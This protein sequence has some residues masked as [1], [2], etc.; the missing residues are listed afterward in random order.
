[1]NTKRLLVSGVAIFALACLS[2]WYFLYL[3]PGENLLPMPDSLISLNTER[4]AE[5]LKTSQYK[6]DYD[7]LSKHFVPQ[8]RMAFC[9]VATSSIV[10]NAL[11][12]FKSEQIN[13]D[14]LFDRLGGGNTKSKFAVTFS[15]M[16]LDELGSIL[17]SLG[18]DVSVYHAADTTL[19][20]F[21]QMAKDNLLD[22][23]DFLVVNYAREVL[24]QNDIGHIS[25]IGAYDEETDRFLI[26][27]VAAHNYPPTWVRSKDL[28]D[29]MNT[30]DVLVDKTRGFALVSNSS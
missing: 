21:V 24:G 19:S 3:P 11:S 13:Q 17:E 14:N 26:L 18:T 8:E 28:W 6:H 9:G 16:T 20:E 27:D 7:Q 15:G 25:P 10:A 5:I 22:N 23:S 30:V 12:L 1:M 2:V 4:G 29:A